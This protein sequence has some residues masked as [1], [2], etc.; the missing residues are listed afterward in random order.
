MNFLKD[1]KQFEAKNTDP[2]VGSSVKT[3]TSKDRKSPTVSA[4]KQ[5][6]GTEMKGN[7]GDMWVVKADKNG[8]NHWKKIN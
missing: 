1:F 4:T 3:R 2:E 5:T 7:D 6:I 8:V